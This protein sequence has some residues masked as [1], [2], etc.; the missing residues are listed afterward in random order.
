MTI[1]GKE[2]DVPELD[3][4]A[5]CKLEADGLSI[6]DLSKRPL[7]FL[8]GFVGL[9]VGGGMAGGEAA[10]TEHLAA[11]GKL[12]ELTAALDEAIGKSG[13]FKKTPVKTKKKS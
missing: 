5:M 12:D 11:G 2:F 4:G 7:G 6:A 10:I 1:N 8:A 13:F 9:A 3:F